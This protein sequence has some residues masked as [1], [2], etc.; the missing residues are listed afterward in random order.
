MRITAIT[1]MKN[2]GPF[3][4]EWLSYHLLIGINDFVVFTNDCEDGTDL[5]L[6]RLDELGF[7]RHLPNPSCIREK[8]DGHHWAA[9]A[10]VDAMPRLRRSDW[11][12][13]FDVDEFV[14][15]NAGQGQMSDLFNAVPDADFISMNQLNFGCAGH[16]KYDPS[17][18]LINRFDRSM[19]LSNAPYGWDRARGIK[20][21]TRGS[22]AF[23]RMGNHSPHVS[24]NDLAWVN[25]NGTPMP[26]ELYQGTLKSVKG[27]NF[28]YDLVQL[29][30]YA[31]RSMENYL[32]KT[33][34]GD[35]NAGAKEEE[36][37]WRQYWNRYDDNLSKNTAIQRW[38]ADTQL[39]LNE[40]T[41][42]A[43]L[44]RL[45]QASVAWHQDRI[46]TLRDRELQSQILTSSRRRHKSK[47]KQ[48]RETAAKSQHAA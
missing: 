16:E 3:I 18:L 22:A 17:S 8:A 35:A 43:E 44:K 2:E 13:S 42:D 12:I 1:P 33:D 27:D 15:V 40:F 47:L 26:P 29:N 41:K 48:E 23:D 36:K 9:M 46:A 21:L 25:G 39:G 34:R 24:R 11:I 37:H 6:E 38:A 28:G 31:L 30:H 5:I 32:V 4:L 10:Y 20:T 19:H 45:H 14:C 7:V